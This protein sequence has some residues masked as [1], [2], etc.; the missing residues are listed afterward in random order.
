MLWVFV[1]FQ[2]RAW[3]LSCGF[4]LRSPDALTKLPMLCVAVRAV[5]SRFSDEREMFRTHR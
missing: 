2:K 3:G 1:F 5:A 4:C